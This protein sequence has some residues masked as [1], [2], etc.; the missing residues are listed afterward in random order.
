MKKKYVVMMLAV[1]MLALSACGKRENTDSQ[2][3]CTCEACANC[4]YKISGEQTVVEDAQDIFAQESLPVTEP[5]SAAEQESTQEVQPS[6]EVPSTVETT[7]APSTEEQKPASKLT[8]G[9]KAARKELQANLAASREALYALPNSLEKTQ[10][11]NEIDKQILANNTYDFS[12]K[13]VQFLGDSI[14][15]GICGAI[16]EDGNYISYVN[17]VNDYLGFANCMNNGKAGRMFSDYAGQELSFSLSMGNMFNNSADIAVIF[18]GINDYL[19]NREN[20][21]YGDIN[22]A[23]STAGYVGALKYTMRQLKS[24]YP[25]QEVFFVTSY[26]VAKTANSTYTDIAG[27]PGLAEYMDTLRK[28]VNENGYH[29]IELYNTGFMDCT[30]SA[31]NSAYTADGLHPSDNG[32]K[33]LGEHIAA[34]LSLYYGQ[35]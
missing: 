15:E 26:N 32:N 23:E 27:S 29:L 30:D 25:N 8:E 3:T 18:L 16:D 5:T 34:E 33:V 13:S 17:Y 6:T 12:V 2:C 31:T 4:I 28:V 14:T 19:T 1:S 21:R 35:K 11:I 10:K 9:E 24:N 20:K 22:A 7:Q